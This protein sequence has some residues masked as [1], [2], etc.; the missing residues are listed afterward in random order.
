[1]HI[2]ASEKERK[3]NIH[4]FWDSFFKRKTLE[5]KEF[6]TYTYFTLH[7]NNRYPCN[8]RENTILFSLI[9]PFP[10]YPRSNKKRRLRG[11]AFQNL[12][13]TRFFVK[14]RHRFSLSSRG[15]CALLVYE[16][17]NEQ[18]KEHRVIQESREVRV[19]GWRKLSDY[20]PFSVTH[21]LVTRV[22]QRER[23]ERL[24]LRLSSGTVVG[25]MKIWSN[26]AFA[27]YRSWE[28]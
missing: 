20:P 14:N 7:G 19:S 27:A 3:K 6:S 2:L 26:L 13:F 12:D 15:R 8:R 22:N 16:S 24:P 25:G 9:P 18:R 23:E 28:K 17:L 11:A 4:E 5:E 21:P 10:L 1:M